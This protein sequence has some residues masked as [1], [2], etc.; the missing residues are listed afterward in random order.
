MTYKEQIQLKHLSAL[1]DQTESEIELMHQKLSKTPKQNKIVKI[2]VGSSF[3]ELALIDD[4][5]RAATIV[6]LQP[7]HLMTIQKEEYKELLER[8]DKKRQE[9]V[10][11]FLQGI[12]YL[13]E[14]PRSLG[15]K[16]I[17]HLTPVTY[18]TRGTVVFEQGKSA[19]C[20]AFILSGEFEIVK[21][22]IT[23]EDQ[24]LLDFLNDQT[25]NQK[26]SLILK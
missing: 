24:V 8:V 15:A 26:L 5:P 19:D 17:F 6:C 4:K 10:M 13:K 7:S 3:G 20:I 16:L 21:F 23:S 12:P 9:G 18:K 25:E 2:G 1:L 22:N 11:E 14:F